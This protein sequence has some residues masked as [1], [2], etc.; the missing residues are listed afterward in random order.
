MSRGSRAKFLLYLVTYSLT[1]VYNNKK[2]CY[3]NYL[4]VTIFVET[5]FCA[6]IHVFFAKP[7]ITNSYEKNLK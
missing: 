7:L 4:Y 6:I 3:I 5:K 2:T 1:E